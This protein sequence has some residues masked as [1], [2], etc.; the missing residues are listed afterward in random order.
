MEHKQ[1]QN[2]SAERLKILAG[3]NL[4][5]DSGDFSPSDHLPVKAQIIGEQL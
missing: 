2:S 4:L 1:A 5:N 3:E